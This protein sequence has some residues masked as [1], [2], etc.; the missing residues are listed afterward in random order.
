MVRWGDKCMTGAA[1]KS[2]LHATPWI[3]LQSFTASHT[4]YRHPFTLMAPPCVQKAYSVTSG[5]VL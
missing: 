5:P 4:M 2:N 1:A 3:V